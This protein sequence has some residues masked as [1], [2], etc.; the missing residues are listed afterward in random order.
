MSATP[1]ETLILKIDGNILFGEGWQKKFLLM[2]KKHIELSN[3]L[4]IQDYLCSRGANDEELNDRIKK[5][6]NLKS[7]GKK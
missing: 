6:Q 2:E 5:L 3:A 7:Y 4:A 1:M